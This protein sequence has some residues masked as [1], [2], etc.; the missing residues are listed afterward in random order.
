MAEQGG[1]SGHESGAGSCSIGHIPRMHAATQ[2]DA[3]RGELSTRGPGSSWFRLCRCRPRHSPDD[4]QNP[5]ASFSKAAAGSGTRR[6]TRSQQ[7]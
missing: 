6:F 4:R 2:W 7:V 5:R 1:S 3:V